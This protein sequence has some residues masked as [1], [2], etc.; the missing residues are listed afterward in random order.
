M[1]AG[2]TTPIIVVDDDPVAR[3][4]LTAYL[5]KEHA[6]VLCA[7]DGVQLTQLL[8]V[9]TDVKLVFLDINL[10]GEDGFSLTAKLRAQYP[11]LGIILVSS[12]HSDV[13]QIVGLELGADDYIIKPYDARLLL[14]R[15]RAVLRRLGA[16]AQRAPKPTGAH[17]YNLGDWRFQLAQRQLQH[18]DGTIRT[19][20]RGEH[21]LLIL[22]CEHAGQVVSRERLAQAIGEGQS[23]D[24]RSLDVLIRRL[25]RK[26]DHDPTESCIVT[27]R[28]EGYRIR[29]CEPNT[30]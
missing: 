17:D 11:Q 14:A 20:T 18:V 2:L 30:L 21:Q 15:T 23:A 16:S 29:Q 3:H 12:R 6:H 22:L 4:R 9:T 1:F 28:G 5:H 25:R 19:L 7:D 27:V 13:D 10:P 8:S 26:L 24:S